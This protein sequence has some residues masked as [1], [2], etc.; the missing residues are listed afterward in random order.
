MK[1][2]FT[3]TLYLAVLALAAFA[4]ACNPEPF[5]T[6]T[7]QVQYSG[8]YILAHPQEF[9]HIASQ[10]ATGWAE[11]GIIGGVV[12]LAGSLYGVYVKAK[13][14]AVAQVNAERDAKRVALGG[15]YIPK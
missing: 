6:A 11:G 3:I 13:N 8:E 2:L 4:L 10:T 15:D 9:V 12:A 5:V 14:A 1:H 7:E